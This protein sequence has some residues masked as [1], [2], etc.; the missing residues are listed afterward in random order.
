MNLLD[1]IVQMSLAVMYHSQINTVK[2]S[3]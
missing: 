1:C 3:W 2:G